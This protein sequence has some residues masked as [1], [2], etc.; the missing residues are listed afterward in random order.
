MN[1]ES[2][3]REASD[4]GEDLIGCL[5]PDVRFWFL[6]S[7][8]EELLDVSRELSDATVTSSSDLLVGEFGEESLDLVDP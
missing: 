2:L 6:V 5:V 7:C 3:P 1:I 8:V 4:A